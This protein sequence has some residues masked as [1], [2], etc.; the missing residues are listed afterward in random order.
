[1]AVGADSSRTQITAKQEGTSEIL[2]ATTQLLQYN[3]INQSI[4]LFSWTPSSTGI[5]FWLG[6][7][8]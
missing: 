6:T 3:I 8:F 1:M 2:R 7:L 5:S 4:N